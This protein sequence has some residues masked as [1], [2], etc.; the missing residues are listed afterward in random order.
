[1]TT[2]EL[3]TKKDKRYLPNKKDKIN[4][5]GS[6]YVKYFTRNEHF[7]LSFSNE[8]ENLSQCDFMLP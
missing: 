8:E 3:G 4:I 1:M 6:F 2:A 7:G 5:L